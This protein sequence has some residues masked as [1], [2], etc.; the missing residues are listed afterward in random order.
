M[1]VPQFG[2]AIMATSN[3]FSTKRLGHVLMFLAVLGSWSQALAAPAEPNKAADLFEMS[4]EQLMDI[5]VISASRQTQKISELSAPV[6]VITAED[7]H[8]SGLRSIP[9]ILQFAPGVDVLQVDRNRYAVGVRGLHEIYSD[10]L[11]SLIDGRAADSITS[12]GPRFPRL[13][14][15]LE[16]IERIEVVRGPGGAA[17]GANAFNGVVNIITKEPQDCLGWLA[18]TRWNHFGDSYSQVRWAQN[19]GRWSWRQSVG[20]EGLESSDDAVEGD[21]FLS[22]DFSRNWRFDGKAIYQASEATKMSF[23]LGHSYEKS[24]DFEFGNRF[25]G[26]NNRLNTIRSFAR[27]DHKFEEDVS[28]YLQVFSNH[29]T[30]KEPALL[31]YYEGENDIEGQL[32]FIP[33]D[34][35]RM[36]VGG[37]FRWVRIDGERT[38]DPEMFIYHGSPL[39]EYW[40]GLFAIDRWQV[41]DRLTIEGQVRGDWYSE[42]QTDWSGRLTTLYALDDEKD[43]V[44]RLSAAKAFRAPLIILRKGSAQRV[45]HPFVPGT[46]LLNLVPPAED[47]HNE[48]TYSLEAGY[49]GRV[50]KNVTLRAD[51]YYQRFE[52]LIGFSTIPD[53]LS[54]GRSFFTPE[55]VDGADSWGTE[56][57]LAVERKTGRVSAW[58]AYNDFE[59]DQGHQELR[60]YLPAKH[61]VGLTGRLHL[62]D[63]WTVNLNYKFTDVTCGD[64]ANPLNRV[65]PGPSHRLDLTFAKRCFKRNGE[66]IFGVSDLLNKDK[67]AV[68]SVGA[69]T[70]HET[71]GRTFFVEMQLRF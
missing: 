11:L 60:A 49:T 19:L 18:S 38:S 32:N 62:D 54:I 50:A 3:L 61:K 30:V 6:S 23:G 7:I 66:F 57:E 24:G 14:I 40:A 36:S 21:N 48:G 15:F 71:P 52:K 47:L 51:G 2:G 63:D 25:L 42:T 4:I 13:P 43:H 58:Y 31:D 53:P 65:N 67:D 28:G 9:D 34:D 20:Y 69:L 64:H 17:W 39:S 35:H 45:P 37:N 70:M 56:L 8:Y 41:S 44:L 46:Y 12:G 10:R 16:D 1:A 55:N 26:H 33:A 59:P 5:E 29:Y 68:P 22:H 27:I